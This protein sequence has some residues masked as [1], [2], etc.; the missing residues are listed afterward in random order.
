M[1]VRGAHGLDGPLPGPHVRFVVI[2]LTNGRGFTRNP[3]LDRHLSWARHHHAWTAAYAFASYPTRWQVDHFGSSGPY[4]HHRYRNRLA[5]AAW[6]EAR[7]NIRTMRWHGFTTPHLWLDIEPTSVHPWHR[8]RT[9]RVVVRTWVRAYRAAGYR[10][11]FYSTQSL[12]RDILGGLSFGL[13][14][15]RTAGP[16]SARAALGMCRSARFQGGPAV[17]AQ[18]WSP[19]RDYDRMCPGFASERA[20]ARYF[21]RY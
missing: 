6:A 20:M 1:G 10:V 16:V 5:N 19:S 4:P 13:P 8:W 3:C 21:H 9:N 11:G 15:W 14:E 2:G 7:Y 18:W 12:W 17:L